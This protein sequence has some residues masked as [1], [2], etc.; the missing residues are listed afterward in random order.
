MSELTLITLLKEMEAAAKDL[1]R[2]LVSRDTD[3]IL[4]ALQKQEAVIERLSQIQQGS[5][6]DLAGVSQRNREVHGLLRRSRAL[7]RTNRV[8]SRTFLQVIDR[9][10]GRLRGTD[11][12]SYSGY[13]PAGTAGRPLLI[14]QEG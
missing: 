6:P 2:H 10:L 3:G 8:L 4:Q 11:T 13:G 5:F 14:C 7:I 9:T 12:S 1:Q